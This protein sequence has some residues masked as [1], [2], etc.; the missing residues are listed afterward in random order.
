MSDTTVVSAI[1]SIIPMPE[2]LP[3]GW[4]EATLR[5]SST[6]ITK[7]TTP[8]TYGFKYQKSGIPFVRVENL[9]NGQIDP[10]SITT[11]IETRADEALRRSR[12]E[13]GDLLFSIAGTI[14][15]TALVRASDVPSNTN[16][17]IAIIRGTQSVFLHQFLLFALTSIATQQQAN[18]DAR[19]GSMNNISL[20]DVRSLRLPI[21]PLCEQKRI[22]TKVEELLSHVS[23]ARDHLSR[24]SAILKRFR[25]AVLA[26]A[27]SGRLTKDWREAQSNLES[28]ESLYE[29]AQMLRAERYQ[30]GVSSA[31]AGGWRKP[32][33]P[34]KSERSNKPVIDLPELPP[35]WGLYPLQ[36][37]S[38]LI[39]DGTHK[40]PNYQG[41][42][43]AFLSVRNVRPFRIVD[44]NV[45]RISEKE[46]REITGRCNPAAGDILYTKIGS[47]GYAAA[48]RLSYPFSLFVSVALIKP[49]CEC[50]TTDYAEL[51]M[52][53]EIVY[54]QAADR[55]SGSGVPDLHLIEI[56]DF[57]IPL[58]SL[59]EQNEIV[60]R[61]E[62][63]FRFADVIEKRVSTATA[64][65]EKLTQSILS[66]A[67][68]GELVPTEAELARRE[69]REYE[70]ASVLLERIRT[71][72][73]SSDSG[74]KE[75]SRRATHQSGKRLSVSR[76][77]VR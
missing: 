57:R 37:L 5:E 61:V 10:A 42:G 3:E 30:K 65:A 7:G 36:D 50:F 55:V 13:S 74:K 18:E 69:G 22:I 45:K 49:V 17:A 28:V 34:R 11:F 52:N 35:E 76:T 14:G 29:R 19:G 53:S 2:T 9:F 15:R 62:S 77:S 73:A 72:K 20:D 31:V 4:A 64:R 46:H 43:V 33:D 41:E 59:A 21:P 12:L 54:S 8:T 40:T 38:Y 44:T 68:R 23:S 39:T 71:E 67:F 32:S 27:C 63:L 58:P 24:V 51:V 25:Q 1:D 66:K 56:R 70:P 47:F 6:L 26:S 75:R 60:R 48:N 16:Q